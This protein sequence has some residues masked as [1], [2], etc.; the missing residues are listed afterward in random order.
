MGNIELCGIELIR[1]LLIALNVKVCIN[2]KENSTVKEAN[3]TG[4]WGSELEE[5]NLLFSL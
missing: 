3:V 1:V 5:K 2:I 4:H